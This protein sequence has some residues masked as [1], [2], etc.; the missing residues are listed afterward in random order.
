MESFWGQVFTV[1]LTGNGIRPEVEVLSEVGAPAVRAAI[2]DEDTSER[3]GVCARRADR[4]G[5]THGC[6]G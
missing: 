6:S 5:D 1:A 4:R 3:V 2:M